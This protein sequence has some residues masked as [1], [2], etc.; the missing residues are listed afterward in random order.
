MHSSYGD[1]VIDTFPRVEESLLGFQP[2]SNHNHRYKIWD[3]LKEFL[4]ALYYQFS[5][6]L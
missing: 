3:F 2:P 6:Y 1:Q 4:S 5:L